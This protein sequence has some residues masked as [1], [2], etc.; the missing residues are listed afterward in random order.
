MKINGWIIFAYKVPSVPSSVRVRVWRNLKMMGVHY[1]QQSV[2]LCPN[3]EDIHK[4]LLKLKLFILENGG[5]VTLL[6][7]EKLSTLSEDYTVSEFNQER[8]LEYKEFIEEVE[9]FLKEIE[10]ETQKLNF[11]FREIEENEAEL[12]RLKN[13]LT[14]IKKRDFFICNLQEK[15]VQKFEECIIAFE[16]FTQN[17][18]KH[19]GIFGEGSA[20]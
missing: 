20:Q 10:D 3:I 5:E 8:N 17:V 18:Y 6:E 12:R 19:E 14:K 9:K 7:V 15:A 2:C 16:D 4:K 13:W 11:S 1:I